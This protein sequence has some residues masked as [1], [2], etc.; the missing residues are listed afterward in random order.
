MDYGIDLCETVSNDNW[1]LSGRL[2][3]SGS[4]EDLKKLKKMEETKLVSVE[5]IEGE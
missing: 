4:K 2:L 3:A 5:D 1:L